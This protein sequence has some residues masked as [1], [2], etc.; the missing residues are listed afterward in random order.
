MIKKEEKKES[1]KSKYSIKL[2]AEKDTSSFYDEYNILSKT[3]DS[4]NVFYNLYGNKRAGIKGGPSTHNDQDLLRAM[5]IF[6]CAGLDAFV[7]KLVKNKLPQLIN[8]DQKAAEK[9][10]EHVKR[11]VKKDETALL[12]IVAF[13][14]INNVPR[15]VF[16]EEY[17]KS[18]TKDSLQSVEELN[19]ISDASGLETKNILSSTKQNLLK[20][21]FEVRNQ[22]IHEMDINMGEGNS[23]KS[24]GYRTR[25]QRKA[26][27]IENYT[28]I[29][30]KLA[31]DL[32]LAYKEKFEKY[33][34]KT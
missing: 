19:K 30:I 29:I 3:V 28:Q 32:F 25:R 27:E 1:I 18:L 20:N 26:P 5:L 21:V 13:A 9:F 14:L 22:I 7:K 2:T 11:G 17:I 34:I 24:T 8:V 15:D 6:A 31:E 16:L 4:V 10:K 33:K 12:N 23:K